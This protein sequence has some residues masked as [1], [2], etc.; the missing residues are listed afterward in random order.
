MKEVADVARSPPV[1]DPAQLRSITNILDTLRAAMNEALTEAM[2]L[3]LCFQNLSR[4]SDSEAHIA[5]Q[6]NL[7]TA[8]ADA[9][10]DA[11]TKYTEEIARVNQVIA[12]PRTV[13][14]RTGSI[15]QRL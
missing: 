5:N 10:E 6:G 4:N 8:A 11:C 1:H 7:A 14:R 9:F 2:E 15:A 13:V 12:D 3:A